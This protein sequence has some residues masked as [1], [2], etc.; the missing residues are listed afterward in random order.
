MKIK[1]IQLILVASC[2]FYLSCQP[3]GGDLMPIKLDEGRIVST[4][5]KNNVAYQ[6][7]NDKF[8]IKTLGKWES[9]DGELDFVVIIKNRCKCE[10]YVDLNRMFL[11]S[12][13]QNKIEVLAVVDESL[14]LPKN[15]IENTVA[16]IERDT[17]RVF[18]LLVGK[19][20]QESETNIKYRG[21]EILITIPV[22]IKESK[23]SVT[24]NYDFRF[25]YDNYQPEAD[26]GGNLID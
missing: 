15:R 20:K 6:Y 21:N 22:T 26:L 17:T 19:N 23:T 3:D 14:P 2:F 25:K 10:I 9:V 7:D 8:S 12:T 13:L 11:S 18:G 1:F 4:Q 5:Y 16:K 24:T